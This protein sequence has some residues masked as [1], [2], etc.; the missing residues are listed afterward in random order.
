MSYLTKKTNSFPFSFFKLFFNNIVDYLDVNT[1]PSVAPLTRVGLAAAA[2]ERFAWG[3][4]FFVVVISRCAC[5]E[6]SINSK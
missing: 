6:I 5:K 1:I 2:P 3:V 4:H